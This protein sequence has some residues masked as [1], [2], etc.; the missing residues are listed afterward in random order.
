[1]VGLKKPEIRYAKS[2]D[3]HIAYQVFGN[4]PVDIV[5]TPGIVS[6]Q[7]LVWEYPGMA[8]FL[9]GLAQFA[10]VAHFDKRGTGLSDRD[11]GIPTYEERMDDIRAVMDAA[12]FEKA[13]LLGFSEGVPMSVLFGASY[14]SR[15]RGLVL[16]GGEARGL[17]AP[18][19]PWASTA[20]DWEAGFQRTE[21]KWGTRE[22]DDR[23]ASFLAP[24]G[25]RDE[26]FMRWLSRVFRM[27]GSP[28]A[29]LALSKSEMMMDVRNI[30]TTVHVPTLVIHLTGD[31]ACNV[32]EGRYLARKIPGAELVE[33]PGIDHLFFVNHQLTDAILAELRKFLSE[34]GKAPETSRV[35]MTV[36]F[37]DI[38][39]S[40]RRAAELGDERWQ[41]LLG[42]HISMV[43]NEIHRFRGEKVKDTGDGFLATF[44]GPSLAIKCACAVTEGAKQMGLEVRA[45]LHT[46]ECTIGAN[47]VGGIAVHI[48][49]RV[50]DL[51]GPSEVV[52]SSTVRDLVIGSKILFNDRGVHQ[53]KGVDQRWHLFSV[54]NP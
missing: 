29:S 38:V 9:E 2:G 40:T 14:P 34:M 12:H 28:G 8:K 26:N 17:W 5:F 6:H 18:D 35:L 44:D 10:R 37:T 41:E 43:E 54:Q 42:K 23:R 25:L 32:E 48:A 31:R 27:G 11:V 21:Q 46:G 51:A 4:G 20:E 33:L 39:D 36:L 3:V 7:D 24:S 50:M 49:A 52:V 15:T 45:G 53:L 13:V 1:M 47:D 30:L 22:L 16:Y 19:Y